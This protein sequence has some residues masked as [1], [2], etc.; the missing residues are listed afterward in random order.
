MT[1]RHNP[2]ITKQRTGTATKELLLVSEFLIILPR[3]MI[4]KR[5][6]TF[7]ARTT[8]AIVARQLSLRLRVKHNHNR[9]HASLKSSRGPRGMSVAGSP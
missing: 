6:I 9:V 4:E 7:M 3:S 1:Q 8:E 2:T 5:S